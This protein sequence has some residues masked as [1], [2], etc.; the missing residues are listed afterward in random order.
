[1]KRAALLAALLAF[2]ACASMRYPD[3]P[4]PQSAF[5]FCTLEND[6]GQVYF[7]GTSEAAFCRCPRSYYHPG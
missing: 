7:V 6:A 2:S 5:D 1:V 3:C 4:P